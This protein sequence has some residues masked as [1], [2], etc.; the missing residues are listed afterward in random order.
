[1]DFKGMRDKA[2]EKISK[3]DFQAAAISGKR[4]KW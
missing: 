4:L 3:T 2:A 1:M